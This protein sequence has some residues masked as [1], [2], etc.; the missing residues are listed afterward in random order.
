MVES[1]EVSDLVEQSLGINLASLERHDIQVVREYDTAL[2]PVLVDKHQVLPILA[3]LI[4]NAKHAMYEDATFTRQLTLRTGRVEGS[5]DVIQLQACDTGIGIKPELFTQG[6]TTKED[7]H[8]FGLHSSALHAKQ[9]GG[10]L[11]V[12]RDG[13]GKGATFTVA[14]PLNREKLAA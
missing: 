8:G 7:G 1:A 10:S 11:S 9:L 12:H 14:L 5:S 13:E 2:P 4:S 6:F 3:N